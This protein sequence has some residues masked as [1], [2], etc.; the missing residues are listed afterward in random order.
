MIRLIAIVFA[1]I[2]LAMP[3]IAEPR[4]ALVI[5]NS[6]YETTGWKLQN[7]ARDARLMKAA[8]EGLGFEVEAIT[9]ADED[10]MEEAFASFGAR[11]KEAGP[12]ATGFFFFAGHGVQSEGL[13]YLIPTELVAYTEADVWANAPRLELLFR[14]LENAGNAANFIVLDACRNNPLP[15][16]VRTTGGGLA[17]T[18]RVRGTL[19]AYSTAPGAVA[20][21]GA[22]RNSEFTLA[23][24]EL[25]SQ[26]GLSA[27]TLFRRV[28]TRVETRTGYRQQ[29]WIESGLRGDADFCF[30]GCETD[31]EGRDEAAA[32]AASLGSDS[33]VVLQSFL[34][35]FPKSR[36]RSL[37]EARIDEL[38][39]NSSVSTG[40]ILGRSL[41]KTEDGPEEEAPPQR[42]EGEVKAILGVSTLISDLVAPWRKD[43]MQTAARAAVLARTPVSEDTTRINDDSLF[44][45]F[46]EGSSALDEEGATNLGL[47]ARYTAGSLPEGTHVKVVAGCSKDEKS[48]SL[49]RE[50]ANNVEQ[51]LVSQGVPQSAFLASQSYG[52][53]RQLEDTGFGID[54]APLNRYAMVQIID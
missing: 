9:N 14:Y 20:E 52:R 3:A 24:A 22:G 40:P 28:A 26:P 12:N 44:V 45:F 36:S 35:A 34:A 42:T 30:A 51:F 7:G 13:N 43:V 50:R 4:I 39:G 32:L 16:A 10:E 31:E 19:I 23:L 48:G 38:D 15:S 27:E 33:A 53:Y 8:L 17:A 11:L 1:V 6:D 37:V 18:G 5:G 21:E 47:Y 2:A 49:C 54:E 41:P 46:E 25:I 29:P